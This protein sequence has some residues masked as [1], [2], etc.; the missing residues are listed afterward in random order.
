MQAYQNF[1]IYNLRTQIAQYLTAELL[2][3]AHFSDFLNLPQL[4]CWQH[5]TFPVI[6][7]CFFNFSD[8]LNHP[9]VI[10]NVLALRLQ[11][12]TKDVRITKRVKKVP[13]KA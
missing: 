3:Q 5:S 10:C 1:E 12:V 7:P 6:R 4:H 8:I 2:A 13:E 9:V 11:H